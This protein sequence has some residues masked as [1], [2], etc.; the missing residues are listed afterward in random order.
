MSWSRRDLAGLLLL[1][2]AACGFHPMYGQEE[3]AVDEPE[4]SAI[5]VG[6]IPDRM[7]QQLELAL[8]EALNP[9]GLTVKP[10]YR[11]SVALTATRV[12]LGIQRDATSTR[13]RI[14]AYVT[15]QVADVATN[16]SIYS[17]RAQSVADFN[18][19]T[20]AYAAQVAEDDA[21]TRTVRDLAAEIRTRLTLFVHDRPKLTQ[22]SVD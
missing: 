2:L 16:K 19:L 14:S 11:L 20:D 4:L 10:R 6:P 22:K 5:A 21:R 17:S 3:E 8:R 18:I 12:D 9:E 1:P 7:G 15:L 13:G